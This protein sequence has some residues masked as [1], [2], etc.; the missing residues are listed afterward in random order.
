MLQTIND[1]D[2][3]RLFESI[4]R[5]SIYEIEALNLFASPITAFKWSE[6]RK[7]YIDFADLHTMARSNIRSDMQQNLPPNL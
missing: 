1:K 7:C 5:F 3:L 2:T 4:E 6:T